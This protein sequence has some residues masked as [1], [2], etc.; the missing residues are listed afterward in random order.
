MSVKRTLTFI[1]TLTEDLLGKSIANMLKTP[2]YLRR[3]FF[4][5]R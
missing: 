4:G 5:K 1:F 2:L 3:I